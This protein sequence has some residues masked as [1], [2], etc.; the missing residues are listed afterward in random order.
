MGG[1]CTALLLRSPS[2]SCLNLLCHPLR[3]I[4]DMILLPRPASISFHWSQSAGYPRVCHRINPTAQRSPRHSTSSLQRRA[5][6]FTSRRPKPALNLP[7]EEQQFKA[8]LDDYALST[9][10]FAIYRTTYTSDKAWN[11]CKNILIAR[12]R[13]L[14]SNSDTPSLADSL[15]WTFFDSAAAFNSASK[16]QLRRHF[17]AWARSA[18]VAENPRAQRLGLELHAPRYRFFVQVDGEAMESVLANSDVTDSNPHETGYV[19]LVDAQ[20]R[21]QADLVAEMKAKGDQHRWQEHSVEDDYEP[22]EGCAEEEVGWFRLASSR[23]APEVYDVL[24]ADE[25][26]WYVEYQRPPAIACGG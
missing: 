12:T 9:W 2:L 3:K 20:W 6:T 24:A 14:I 22:V 17:R 15:K 13:H 23:M 8:L 16:D 18:A 21:S 5:R 19:N 10:G 1:D 4:S 25:S 11:G 7:S 26:M